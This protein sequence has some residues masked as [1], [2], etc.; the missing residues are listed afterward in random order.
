[1]EQSYGLE[2][3]VVDAEA[4]PSDE[5][6]AMIDFANLSCCVLQSQFHKTTTVNCLLGVVC[7]ADLRQ[8]MSKASID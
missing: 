5:Q 6:L 1:M 2:L 8:E 3:L 4:S 7:R